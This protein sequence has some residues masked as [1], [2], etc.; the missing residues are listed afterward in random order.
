MTMIEADAVARAVVGT[1]IRVATPKPRA[2]AGRYAV[3]PVDTTTMPST[4]PRAAAEVPRAG[5]KMTM[6]VVLRVA[7]A[8]A[9]GL[10]TRK[11]TPR[12]RVVVGKSAAARRVRG[13]MRMTMMIAVAPAPAAA[14]SGIPAATQKRPVAGGAI[15]IDDGWA[16]E[17]ATPPRLQLSLLFD[18]TPNVLL[19]QTATVSQVT[20][21][22]GRHTSN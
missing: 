16:S 19:H 6:I 7:A 18:G 20:V 21:V 22:H 14:G 4:G 5:T 8:R 15:A 10:A 12:P 11:A 3:R 9:A 2:R 1:A 17:A 13:V